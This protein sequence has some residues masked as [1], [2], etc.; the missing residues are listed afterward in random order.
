MAACQSTGTCAWPPSLSKHQKH[1]SSLTLPLGWPEER[2]DQGLARADLEA[3]DP[4]S[5]AQSPAM[6][7]MYTSV[8]A[9]GPVLIEPLNL[10]WQGTGMHLCHV[11]GALTPNTMLH[12]YAVYSLCHPPGALKAGP[13]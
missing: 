6:T 5:L 1:T 13:G 9:T 7:M 8:Y 10:N 11:A 3:H 2:Q 12:P 4:P